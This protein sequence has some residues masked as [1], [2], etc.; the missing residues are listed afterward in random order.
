LQEIGQKILYATQGVE[1]YLQQFFP[2][3]RSIYTGFV[4]HTALDSKLLR[5]LRKKGNRSFSYNDNIKIGSGE[6]LTNGQI[7]G[8]G[9][10]RAV[11]LFYTFSVI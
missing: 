3:R 9:P 10:S 5:C 1:L 4:Y 7:H 6:I 2:N 11:L 8:G